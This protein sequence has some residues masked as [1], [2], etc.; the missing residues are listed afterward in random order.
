M[1]TISQKPGHQY[2]RKLMALPLTAAAVALFAFTYKHKKEIGPP[3]QTNKTITVV[4]DAGHGGKDEGV[5]GA[6]GTLEKDIVLSI[7]KKVKELNTDDHI[8][9]IL[10]RNRDEFPS[11]QSRVETIRS[12]KA[13]L[14]LSLHINAAVEKTNAHSGVEVT[15]SRKNEQFNAENQIFASILSNYFSQLYTT[16]MEAIRGQRG[17]YVLDNAPCPSALIQCGYMTNEKDLAYIKSPANQEKM[18]GAILSAID[19]YALQRQSADWEG[20]K[21]TFAPKSTPSVF[22]KAISGSAFTVVVKNKQQENYISFMADSIVVNPLVNTQEPLLQE[23]LYIFNGQRKNASFFENK[24]VQARLVR[25]FPRSDAATIK[26]FGTGAENGVIVFENALLAGNINPAPSPDTSKPRELTFDKVEVEPSFPG[27]DAA[28]RKYLESNLD[29]NIPL[30]HQAPPGAYSVVVMFIVDKE[31]N[32]ADV[33]TLTHLGYGMEEE[34]LR[35]I[36]AGPKWLP[37]LQ[38]GKVV[39]AYRKQPITFVVQN[40]QKEKS[41]A[42]QTE[43]KPV[44]PADY[45]RFPGGEI[46]WQRFLMQGLNANVPIDSAAPAGNY[47]VLVQFLVHADGTLSDFKP[48]TK[49]GYGMEQEVIRA[50]S[51]GPKWE[52][53]MQNG[54]KINAYIKQPVTFSITEETE[55]TPSAPSNDSGKGK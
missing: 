49:M 36:K 13:D 8:R 15:I 44:V 7:A 10:T 39:R 51:H 45:P 28:W 23:A 14:F 31:G 25:V 26:E 3:G 21:E 6:D 33:R 9:I 55:T 41:V 24:A 17:I 29:A 22:S 18:A 50:L 20:R 11:L 52:P 43:A 46:A 53:A 32:L 19:Q 30:R 16:N 38:N 40:G 34:A 5:Q 2:L 12:S 35:V 27:G 1:I 4:L 48:L 47:K 37:A 42:T 54:K